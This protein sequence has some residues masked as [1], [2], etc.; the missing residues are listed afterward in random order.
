MPVSRR[1][2]GDRSEIR[3]TIVMVDRWTRTI[4]DKGP[5]DRFAYPSKLLCHWGTEIGLVAVHFEPHCSA[6]MAVGCRGALNIAS[7][8]V[9]FFGDSPRGANIT[10]WCKSQVQR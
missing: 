7:K 4:I 1:S 5:G 2:P 10:G 9:A 6:R 3:G 8:A